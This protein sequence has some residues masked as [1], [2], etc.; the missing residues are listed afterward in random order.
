MKLVVSEVQD[1]ALIEKPEVAVS[2]PRRLKHGLYALDFHPEEVEP[3][4]THTFTIVP[5]VTFRTS[6]LSIPS[7]LAPFFV[8]NAISVGPNQQLPAGTSIPGEVFDETSTFG[9][10]DLDFARPQ[11]EIS[12]TVTNTDRSP[13][14]FTA[15][16]EGSVLP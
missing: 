11:M 12:V 9:R 15:T 10:L 1:G 13:H 7:E 3:N 6:F 2:K 16:L 14:V 5:R 4:E 8:V